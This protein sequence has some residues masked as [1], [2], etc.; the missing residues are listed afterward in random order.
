[1]A[2]NL[3]NDDL[4]G[5][6]LTDLYH[7]YSAIFT[8]YYC[9]ARAPHQATAN[10]VI[11]KMM[12]IPESLDA[13]ARAQSL[14]NLINDSNFKTYFPKEQEGLIRLEFTWRGVN[15]GGNVK[16]IPFNQFTNVK[17]AK[18]V[19]LLTRD[20]LMQVLIDAPIRKQIFAQ[21]LQQQGGRR[22]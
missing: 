17:P 3:N 13:D 1:M 21:W 2:Y 6:G 5:S 19:R 9:D 18:N 11:Q 15:L 16:F 14:S 20:S 7:A 4:V 22:A 12:E 10:F 8:N